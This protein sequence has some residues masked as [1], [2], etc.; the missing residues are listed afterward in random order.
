MGHTGRNCEQ[1]NTLHANRKYILLTLMSF[2]HD[3]FLICEDPA[4]RSILTRKATEWHV[5]RQ[6]RDELK[7]TQTAISIR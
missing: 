6:K 1:L 7:I 5:K 3:D 2:F 4:T